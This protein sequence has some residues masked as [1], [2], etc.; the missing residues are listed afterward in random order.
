ML[1][2]EKLNNLL[3]ISNQVTAMQKQLAAIQAELHM[4]RLI[5]DLLETS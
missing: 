3:E 2:Q 4:L 1:E 5:Y